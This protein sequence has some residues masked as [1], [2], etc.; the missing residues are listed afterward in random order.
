MSSIAQPL[1]GESKWSA[2]RWVFTIVFHAALAAGIYLLKPPAKQAELV[3]ISV[4]DEE[5]KPKPKP[6]PPPEIEEAPAA[7]QARAQVNEPP[8]NQTSRSRAA[9]GPAIPSLGGDAPTGGTGGVEIPTTFSN[10]SAPR[11]PGPSDIKPGPAPTQTVAK[12]LAPPPPSDGQCEEP[13]QKPKPKSVPQPAYPEAARAAEVQ[14]KVRVEVTVDESGA[15]V[16]ARVVSGLGHGLDEAALAAA[17]SAKFSPAMRCGKAVRGTFV[18]GM[19][20]TL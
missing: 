12:S 2:G 3:T 6:P 19:R 1:E 16:S 7:P 15:V 20:F 8:R 5:E 9:P 13:L 18:I 4:A 11:G 17:R 10:D 14:G